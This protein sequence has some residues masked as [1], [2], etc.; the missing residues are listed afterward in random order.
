MLCEGTHNSSNISVFGTTKNHCAFV[1]TLFDMESATVNL[2]NVAQSRLA[3]G[4]EKE[5][6]IKEKDK[7]EREDSKRTCH[8]LC[9]LASWR[10]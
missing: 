7:D 2:L 9:V 10:C 5:K 8:H 3:K 1:F 6:N 4:K